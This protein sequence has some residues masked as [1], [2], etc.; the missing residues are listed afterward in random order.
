MERTEDTILQ[1]ALDVIV[2]GG[3][4]ALRYREVAAAAGVALGTISYQFPTREALIR[5]AFEYFLAKSTASLRAFSAAARVKTVE[6]LAGLIAGI[7]RAE[8]LD[9][10]KA[11]LAEYELILF[12]ARDEDL[13]RA[14]AEWDRTLVAELGSLVEQ[15]GGTAPFSTAQMILELTRGFQ[16][17]AL[18]QPEPHFEDFEKRVLRLLR[19]F[20]T[21][22]PDV[23]AAEKPARAPRK[24][25]S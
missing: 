21:H 20:N 11:R 12:A 14:L 6:E 19:A 15:V 22:Q 9:P 8:V 3:V 24:R 25:S 16:L 18:S 4:G 10:H 7:L 5:A 1:A 13:A 23:K 17:A 2:K